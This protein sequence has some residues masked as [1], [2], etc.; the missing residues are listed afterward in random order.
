MLRKTILNPNVL[1][2][3]RSP[4][5]RM[6][7]KKG[8]DD[9]LNSQNKENHPLTP[10]NS[11]DRTKLMET[12]RWYIPLM[13]RQ[14]ICIN[15]DFMKKLVVKDG[16]SEIKRKTKEEL[17]RYFEPYY[18]NKYDQPYNTHIFAGTIVRCMAIFMLIG[19]PGEISIPCSIIWGMCIGGAYSGMFD[20][21]KPNEMI[22]AN[23]S[24]YRNI[25]NDEE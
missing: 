15:D 19:V 23:L 24:R 6:V 18:G 11:R 12:V 10:Q 13:P 25:F 14:M 1:T 9:I 22:R 2:C 4:Q 21:N 20:D 8:F 17:T 3:F 7:S 5:V 16:D